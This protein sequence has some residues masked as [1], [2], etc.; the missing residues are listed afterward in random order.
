MGT[1]PCL[2]LAFAPLELV[3]EGVSASCLGCWCCMVSYCIRYAG[4]RGKDASDC[5]I[6]V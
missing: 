1:L 4:T 6:S 5:C 2:S 3:E